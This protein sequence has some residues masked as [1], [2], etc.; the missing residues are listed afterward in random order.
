MIHLE[1]GSDGREARVLVGGVSQISRWLRIQEDASTGP[2]R[3]FLTKR[4]SVLW[5]LLPRCPIRVF[6]TLDAYIHR[7]HACCSH[8]F[9]VGQKPRT[10]GNAFDIAHPC[11]VTC[12]IYREQRSFKTID[13]PKSSLVPV[14]TFEG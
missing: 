9:A 12:R 1:H 4:A 11:R 14:R 8:K 3:V 5:S 13:H 10:T 7:V 2:F 6:S